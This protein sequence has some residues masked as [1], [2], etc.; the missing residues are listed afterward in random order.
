MGTRP[1]YTMQPSHPW[2]PHDYHQ[3]RH[4]QQHHATD[5]DDDDPATNT[6]PTT[7]LSTGPND[8]NTASHPTMA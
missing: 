3:C 1:A 2:Q 4:R 6:T 5:D 7:T 8:G